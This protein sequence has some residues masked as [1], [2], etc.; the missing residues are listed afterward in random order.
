MYGIWIKPDLPGFTDTGW[1]IPDCLI[2][3]SY[4][5]SHLISKSTRSVKWC[6]FKTLIFPLARSIGENS[7]RWKTFLHCHIAGFGVRSGLITPFKQKLESLIRESPKSPPYAQYSVPSMALFTSPWSTQSQI[8]PPINR[9][10]SWI[11]VQ[12]D[13]RS[14]TELPMACAYSQ[15]K[16]G[17]VSLSQVANWI[18]SDSGLYMRLIIST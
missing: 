14:P 4:I 13:S 10:C 3:P 16:T 17:L 8:N 1:T 9:L 7:T 11:A 6:L 2:F 18:I 15:Y 5:S 12:K